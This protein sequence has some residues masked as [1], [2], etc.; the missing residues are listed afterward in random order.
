MALLAMAPLPLKISVCL[1]RKSLI[2]CMSSSTGSESPAI[3]PNDIQ[4]FQYKLLNTSFK[5][6]AESLAI[7]RDYRKA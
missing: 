7:R 5:H 1:N 3:H 6:R 2:A 4:G